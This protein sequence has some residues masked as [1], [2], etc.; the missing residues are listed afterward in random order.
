VTVI[1]ERAIVVA[2]RIEAESIDAADAAFADLGS[3]VRWSLPKLRFG[4]VRIK[5]RRV[6]LHSINRTSKAWR[7]G[8]YLATVN[9]EE[10]T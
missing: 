4:D 6:D 3:R 9:E 8:K 10:N 1:V 5:W 2:V 7:I